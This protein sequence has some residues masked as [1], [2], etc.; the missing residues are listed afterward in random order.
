MFRFANLGCAIAWL[1]MGAIAI[2]NNA[3]IFLLFLLP[4]TASVLRQF[5]SRVEVFDSYMMV[6]NPMRT[7]RLRFDEIAQFAVTPSRSGAP[8]AWV[9]RAKLR[10][11]S[12]IT[13]QGSRNGP[14]GA[15]EVWAVLQSLIG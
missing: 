2:L 12:C 14:L 15:E 8:F 4:A 9:V 7:T 5:T 10:S 6:R 11:G 1:V 13:L 3:P